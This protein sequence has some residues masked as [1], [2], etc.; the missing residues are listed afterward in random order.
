M[1]FFNHFIKSYNIDYLDVFCYNIRLFYSSESV[2][3]NKLGGELFA[4][5]ILTV[6]RSPSE[7]MLA[8]IA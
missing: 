2:H 6:I 7:M 1:G 4:V 3:F 5:K 8:D